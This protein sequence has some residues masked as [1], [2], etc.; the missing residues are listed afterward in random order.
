MFVRSLFSGEPLPPSGGT[1]HLE[2]A[3]YREVARSRR[4]GSPMAVVVLT[5]PTAAR[6][7]SGRSPSRYEVR[8]AALVRRY[9]QVVVRSPQRLVMI[10]PDVS[11]SG[12]AVLAERLRTRLEVQA[13]SACFPDD[14]STADE[15][16]ALAVRR[17]RDDRARHADRMVPAQR[18][19][20]V[21]RSAQARR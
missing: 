14:A 17:A 1:V 10:A 13:G 4:N 7:F 9:D 5:V 3:V 12:A 21:A 16:L 18:T 2:D 8:A 15:L 19:F 11:S 20:R 6:R